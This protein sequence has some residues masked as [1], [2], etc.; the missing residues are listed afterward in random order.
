MIKTV[1]SL[2]TSNSFPKESNFTANDCREPPQDCIFITNCP[3]TKN[4]S[5]TI[6]VL[7]VRN[8]VPL[9]DTIKFENKCCYE[10]G[11]EFNCSE[12]LEKITN[13][14][15]Q[16]TD[17][18]QGCKK[19]FSLAKR[20]EIRQRFNCSMNNL[21]NHEVRFLHDWYLHR[22]TSA[23]I[24]EELYHLPLSTHYYHRTTH[25]QS[26]EAEFTFYSTLTDKHTVAHY[27]TC[28][29]CAEFVKTKR[30]TLRLVTNKKAGG[31]YVAS[32]EEL[33]EFLVKSGSICGFTGMQ[34]SWVP[35][36][37]HITPLS[38]GGSSDVS[39]LQVTLQFLNN[40]KGNYESDD[41]QKWL[42]AFTKHQGY[43]V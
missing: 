37:D 2:P 22:C 36:P 34:G 39:N 9:E 7:D 14:N 25:N 1:T 41:F 23:T 24:T 16:D 10:C 26:D 17:V 33:F 3:E 42:R 31:E 11:Q 29:G 27:S 13:R 43:L 8:T 4:S 19:L 12:G 32:T 20:P 40:V 38:G 6:D 18:C 35:F 28:F 30:R 5:R 15:P 21:N